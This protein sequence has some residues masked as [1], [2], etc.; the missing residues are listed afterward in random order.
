MYAGYCPRAGTPL[1]RAHYVTRESL[2][3]PPKSILGVHVRWRWG[4]INPQMAHG[5]VYIYAGRLPHGSGA[6]P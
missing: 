1:D 4:V 6:A 2:R 3:H 5:V